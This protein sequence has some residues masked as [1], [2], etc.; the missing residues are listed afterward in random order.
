MSAPSLADETPGAVK[1]SA[2]DAEE[3][4]GVRWRFDRRVM[5]ILFSNVILASDDETS[6]STG[7]WYG[8][9]I[10][11]HRSAFYFRYLVVSL[12]A[13]WTM[14]RYPKVI[15]GCQLLWKILLLVT[16]LL[17]SFQSLL[18]LRIVLGM[19]GAPIIPG[20]LPS[21]ACGTRDGR[22]PFAYH[23]ITLLITG[24]IR[25]GPFFL[26][27][28]G[29]TIFWAVLSALILPDSP[30]KAKFLS[31]R[32]KV[33]V[34]ARISANQTGIENKQPEDVVAVF[35]NIFVA[36]PNGGLT[37]F[38]TLI[39]N[40]LGYS[41]PPAAL[42]K[43]LT[44]VTETVAGFMCNGMVFLV[45]TRYGTIFQ[46]PL[47][48]LHSRP[49]T[50][51]VR[52]V[53]INTSGYTKKVVLNGICFVSNCVANTIGLQFFEAHQAPLS[54][55]ETSAI[56]GSRHLGIVTTCL[57]MAYCAY[58]NRRRDR[59]KGGRPATHEDADFVY[60]LDNQNI[61]FRYAWVVWCELVFV[62]RV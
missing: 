35:F 43:I 33:A 11:C 16:G 8:L 42:L 51:Y 38:T 37:N 56:W 18:D 14:Q 13:A 48:A 3:D 61:H 47:D 9:E 7:V 60:L 62:V 10:D 26:I 41:A 28:G 20:G 32:E 17:S 59:L 50:L 39:V 4:V 53:T 57:Y 45:S 55:L 31:E 15:V 27:L 58:K 40:G 24:S 12:H 49:G 44:G 2:S 25:Y 21:L 19:L 29:I 34:V 5:P 46:L 36:I 22:W 1:V 30:M 6:T 23:I 54:P 52:F